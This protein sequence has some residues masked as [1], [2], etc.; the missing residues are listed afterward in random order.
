MLLAV[1]DY[2]CQNVAP[3]P[4]LWVAPLSLYL[5]SFIIAF[6]HPRWYRRALFAPAM[7]V[8]LL[9]VAYEPSL[10][11][12]PELVLYFVGLFLVCMVCHGELAQL[13]PAPRY[14]TEYFLMLSAGGAIGGLFV[15]IIAPRIFTTYYEWNIG[16]IGSFL[17]AAGLT[18][19][20]L[21]KRLAATPGMRYGVALAGAVIAIGGAAV[22][23]H[24]QSWSTPLYRARSF[25]GLVSVREGGVGKPFH[26]YAFVS[27]NVKH[28]RQYADPARRHEPISYFAPHTGIGQA[29]RFMQQKAGARVGVVG[30]G[31]G[32][33]A[34]YARPGQS[35]RFYEINPQVD[36]IARE[37]FTFLDD[38][39]GDCQVVLGDA[40]LEL[41]RELA[42]HG[43][44]KF[45]LLCLDAFSG[46]SVPAHLL[47]SEAFGL[48]EQHLAEGG[49][50]CFNITNTYLDLSG[51]IEGL[52]RER[53]YETRRIITKP[54][55]DKLY[56]RTDFMLVSKNREF[57]ADHPDVLP[58][59][60]TERTRTPTV[61]TDKF[62]NVLGILKR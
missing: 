61:W 29:G 51:V 32:T 60:F 31:I 13:R 47:T 37:Y 3:V 25:Y 10:G 8:T 34:T 4:L 44:H 9:I 14:L 42:A 24:W 1:T 12:V 18:M 30:M 52:A 38:C 59:G 7:L 15:S 36:Y 17:L 55:D 6:D 22:I 43:S 33:M 45:D 48:Y 49:I 2:V 28:G 26:Y 35:Y 58:E 27:G 40:R 20:L 50:L 11:F 5:L 16:L 53:G 56:Y 62:S 23:A 39:Q 46:D 41:E 54:D 19:Q 57:L 21:W